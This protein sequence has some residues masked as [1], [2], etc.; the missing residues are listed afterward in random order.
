[1]TLTHYLSLRSRTLT[2][3][4]ARTLLSRSWKAWPSCTNRG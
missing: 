2:P 3:A 1:M 4:E